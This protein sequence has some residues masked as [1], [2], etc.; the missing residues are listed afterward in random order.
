MRTGIRVKRAGPHLE[1]RVYFHSFD[2]ANYDP[3]MDLKDLAKDITFKGTL[4][5]ASFGKYHYLIKLPKH[6]KVYTD[7]EGAGGLDLGI[8]KTVY[9]AA[10]YFISR[11][12]R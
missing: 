7:P 5:D 11:C 12:R 10:I 3:D 1:P 9:T 8:Y 4:E 6:Y 2:L